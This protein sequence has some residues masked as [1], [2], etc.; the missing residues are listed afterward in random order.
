[1]TEILVERRM[2]QKDMIRRFDHLEKQ[3]KE[4]ENQ[5]KVGLTHPE[6]SPKTIARLGAIED[7]MR[8]VKAMNAEWTKTNEERH[9][10]NFQKL[11]R[12]TRVLFGDPYDKD[13][14][15][16]QGMVKDIHSKLAGEAGF[17]DRVFFL[18]KV[19]GGGTAIGYA[20][21]YIIQAIKK[22]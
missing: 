5:I 7:E 4:L 15:G 1:M 17:W 13:D 22:F 3:I 19:A 16:M 2:S 10:E 18:A 8:E 12:I 21:Y 6:P 9:K 20:G 14:N 11:E